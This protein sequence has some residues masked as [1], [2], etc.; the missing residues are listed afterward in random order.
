MNALWSRAIAEELRRAGCAHA[1]LCPGSRNSPLLFALD[2]AFGAAAL[3]HVDE[4]SAA[5]L[6]LGLARAAGAP[7]AV[8]VTSGSALANVLPAVAEAHGDGT[9]L[10]VIAAD[11]PWEQHGCAAPQT[12]AQVQAA[13]RWFAHE[14][15]LGEPSAGDHAVRRLRAAVSRAAQVRGPVLI[16]VPLREPLLDGSVPAGL[17]QAALAGRADGAAYTRGCGAPLALDGRR[18]VIAVGP[19]PVEAALVAALADATGLPVLADAASGLRRPGSGVICHGDALVGGAL[20]AAPPQAVVQIGPLP[21]TRAVFSWLDRCDGPWLA[22]AEGDQDALARADLALPTARWRA[23]IS[24]RGDAAW[25]A[26]WAAADARAAERLDA[27][28]AA[29]PWSEV[30]AAHLAV[31]HGGFAL[32][33]AA[34][35]LAVRHVNL[36]AGASTQRRSASR[37]VNGID[38]TLGTFLGLAL[39]A[40][41]P[42]LCLCGD[43]AFLHDLPALA[44]ARAL[45]TPAAVVL[46][47]NGGGAIFD[48]L[49]VAA[50][51]RA[52]DRVRTPQTAD[53]AAIARGFGVHVRRAD[54]RCALED[55]LDEAARRPGLTV[56]H[57]AVAGD[58]VAPWR[59]LTAQLAA[60]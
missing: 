7:A 36:H 31:R 25:A 11:R 21:L 44:A 45:T 16:N 20:G 6:A 24:G 10:I 49:A 33:H 8:C 52:R 59:A 47:D 37:G 5:F 51:P 3:S 32:L 43:L 42:A 4:R 27:W 40:R 54:D 57:A 2:A 58:A 15:A 14:L 55:A 17:S 39:G 19:R 30:L 48:F 34:N 22:L 50:H 23:G 60:P 29:A 46:L 18:G 38:G 28:A 35:S 56:I 26:A 9:P 53:L 41:A 1:V 13:P 12:L